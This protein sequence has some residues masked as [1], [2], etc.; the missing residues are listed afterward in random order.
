MTPVAR[1][2]DAVK[3]INAARHALDDV[4]RRTDAHEIARLVLRH[5][6]LD[7][8]DSVVHLLM[9]LTDGEAADRIARQIK[10]R[11]LLHVFYAH[12]VKHRALIYAEQHLAWIHGVVAAV[13]IGNRSLAALEPAVGAVARALNIFARRGYL[14]ALVK[15]HGNIRAEIRLDAHALL[16]PHEYMPPVNVGVEVYA[17][18]SDLAELCE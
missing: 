8:R 4:R 9:R 15:G 17:L 2:H 5:I 7:R 1:R 12:I 16:R 3:E 10:L 6:L 11:Y 18:L 14:Y 13:V